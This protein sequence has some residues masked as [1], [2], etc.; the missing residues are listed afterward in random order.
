MTAAEL[1]SDVWLVHRARMVLL[2]ESGIGVPFL[3]VQATDGTIGGTTY[4]SEDLVGTFPRSEA[5]RVA[6]QRRPH[7]YVI[8]RCFPSLD[9]IPPHGVDFVTAEQLVPDLPG[10]AQIT[11]RL[12]RG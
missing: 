7:G 2:S 4:A 12:G 3:C 5:E 1:R 10:S 8:E 11:G 9:V 6:R